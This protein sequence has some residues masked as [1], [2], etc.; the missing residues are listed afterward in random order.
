VGDS[1]FANYLLRKQ[2]KEN[3]L[4]K[5]SDSAQPPTEESQSTLYTAWVCRRHAWSRAGLCFL[6]WSSTAGATR[7]TG[8]QHVL[9]A[10]F[11]I[12][13]FPY[14]KATLIPLN[15]A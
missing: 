6:G 5:M 9:Y 12:L 3:Q 15:A 11:Q 7:N 8:M 2:P 13:P 1:S 10:P 4:E 14:G